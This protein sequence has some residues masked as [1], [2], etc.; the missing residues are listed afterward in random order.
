[1]GKLQL[2]G[3]IAK[4]LH[5]DRNVQCIF[6]DAVRSLAMITVKFNQIFVLQ[7]DGYKT[8]IN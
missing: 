3:R 4:A 6:V 8:L 7:L 2:K 5:F 1:M